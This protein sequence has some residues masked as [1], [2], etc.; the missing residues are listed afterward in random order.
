MGTVAHDLRNP[1]STILMLTSLRK[2]REG[3]P[4]ESSQRTARALE[5]AISR[6]DRLIRDLLDV[7]RMDAGHLTVEPE[8][9]SARDIIVDCVETER[10]L[11]TSASLDLQLEV[12]ANLPCVSADRHRL[13][14]ILENLIGN[15]AK[16]TRPGGRITVAARPDGGEVLFWVQDTG[17][18]IA[19]EDLPHLFDRFWQV[20][21]E[22][23]H[24]GLGLGLS[25][26]KGL[27]E[28]HGGRIWVE[29][30]PNRGTTVF[31]TLPVVQA[32][33]PPQP[34]ERL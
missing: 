27:V 29:S 31:F 24:R 17:I 13:T 9:V 21:R 15:A 14:Q 10:G 16:F 18:G 3:Q 33:E 19:P 6:M 11:L 30:T 34:G 32:G 4:T 8:C 25:I 23:S 5:R 2:R 12:A 22:D 1:L 7:T 20:H 26:V 28:A